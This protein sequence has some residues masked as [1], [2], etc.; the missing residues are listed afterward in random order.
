MQEEREIGTHVKKRVKIIMSSQVEE[1]EEMVEV[2]ERERFLLR[3]KIQCYNYEKW[4][5][6]LLLNVGMQR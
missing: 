1:E 5:H 2:K 4:G 6:I 3:K